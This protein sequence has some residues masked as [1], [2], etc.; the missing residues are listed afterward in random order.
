MAN[1]SALITGL[2]GLMLNTQE[3]SFLKETRPAGIIL[4]ARNIESH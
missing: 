3:Q 2:S 1:R 4:F